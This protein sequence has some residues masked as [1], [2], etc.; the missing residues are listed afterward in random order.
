LQTN[1]KV[2]L[3]QEFQVNAP[4]NKSDQEERPCSDTIE[5]IPHDQGWSSQLGSFGLAETEFNADRQG[6][7]AIVINTT[8]CLNLEDH[9]AA[10]HI[11]SRVDHDTPEPDLQDDLGSAN[12]ETAPEQEPDMRQNMTGNQTELLRMHEGLGAQNNEPNS[13]FDMVTSSLPEGNPPTPNGE[14]STI[15]PMVQDPESLRQGREPLEVLR[16]FK[17]TTTSPLSSFILETPKH[18]GNDIAQ[19]FVLE[20]GLEMTRKS[21]RV[22]GKA[23]KEKSVLKLAQNLVTKKCGIIQIE[24]SLDE[25][26]LQD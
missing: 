6:T 5:I 19:A 17:E 18:K 7:D 8:V 9:E 21:P 2:S 1:Q 13:M 25:M 23:S 14:D 22:S 4:F 3:Q 26:T 24:E 15:S 10:D 11:I 16:M 12:L 20:G